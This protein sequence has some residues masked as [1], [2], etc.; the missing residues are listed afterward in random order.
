MTIVTDSFSSNSLSFSSTIS[1][2][3]S[4]TFAYIGN[5]T[6]DVQNQINSINTQLLLKYQQISNMTNYVQN[7]L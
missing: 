4:S 1:N 3:S 7:H 6:S 5:L 2:I